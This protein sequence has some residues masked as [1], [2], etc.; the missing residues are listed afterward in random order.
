MYTHGRVVRFFTPSKLLK[1]ADQK[2]LNT[3]L[4]LYS[5]KE[6]AAHLQVN[7]KTVSRWSKGEGRFKPAYARMIESLGKTGKA[8]T[9]PVRT[10]FTFIDLFAGIGGFRMALEP[11]SGKCLFISEYDSYCEK[12]YRANFSVAG[13]LFRQ[14]IREV[15]ADDIPAHDVLAAG[16]PCQRFSIAGVSKKRSLGQPDGIACN[17]Q[18]TLFLMLHGLLTVTARHLNPAIL[19][20][21]VRIIYDLPSQVGK[22]LL[23]IKNGFIR[24]QQ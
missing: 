23:I 8:L 21:L 6:V 9:V 1:T 24:L 5:R 17:T 2:T 3:V 14:D 4:K 18:G 13:H 19:R 22:E 20:R 11:S 16:F 15:P 10:G 7:P 12:T